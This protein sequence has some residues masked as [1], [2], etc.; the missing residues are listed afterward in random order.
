MFAVGYR[1]S[2]VIFLQYLFYAELLNDSKASLFPIVSLSSDYFFYATGHQPVLSQ[3]RWIAAFPTNTW[4]LND[5]LSSI[6]NSL[7]V[8]GILV[9]CE[10]FSGQILNVILLRQMLK[11]RRD[12]Q[13]FQKIIILDFLRISSVALSVFLFKR[14]LM[15]WKIFSPR[16]LFQLVAL[17][18]KWFFIVSTTD[19]NQSSLWSKISSRSIAHLNMIRFILIQ[20]R[21]GKTRLAKWF[22]AEI[23]S[24]FRHFLF[25][26][27]KVHELSRRR[28]TE[29][30]RRS[31]RFGHRSRRQTHQ[32]KFQTKSWQFY[33]CF[34]F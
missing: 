17:I 18:V 11:I 4:A 10:T 2:L 34:V 28:K 1:F 16:F 5:F 31:S 29:V 7:L 9:L 12:E 14:H 22:V 25:S 24:E 8:R 32:V 33:Q 21:A 15:L 19:F 3:I 20:N 23:E 27:S 6:I 13:I 26:L 30:N